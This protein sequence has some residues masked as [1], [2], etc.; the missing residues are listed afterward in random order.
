MSEIA[1]MV[2]GPLHGRILRIAGKRWLE[3][4]VMAGPRH[5]R[6]QRG[7]G[8]QTCR[9]ERVR[10]GVYR[11]ISGYYEPDCSFSPCNQLVL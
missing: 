10:A 1:K 9:Y 7:R 8:L 3:I 5:P 4:P 11:F 6:Q 2:G